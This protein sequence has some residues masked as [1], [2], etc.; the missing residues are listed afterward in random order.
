MGLQGELPQT[1]IYDYD[2]QIIRLHSQGRDYVTGLG[3][4]NPRSNGFTIAKEYRS[5]YYIHRTTIYD[6]PNH[7]ALSNPDCIITAG[8]ATTLRVW[9]G[10]IPDPDG[11]TTANGI[12]G[13]I[14]THIDLRL[15]H[16]NHWASFAGSQ[17]RYGSGKVEPQIRWIY[18]C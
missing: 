15:R 13:R 14:T 6:T 7:W 17:L 9:E 1:L 3:R 2:T 12:T 11:F 8:V 18:N 5:N 4:W 16:T 10:G